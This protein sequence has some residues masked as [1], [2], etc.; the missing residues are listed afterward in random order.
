M[1]SRAD[2]QIATL[3]TADLRALGVH[4]YSD[5]DDLHFNQLDEPILR[6]TAPKVVRFQTEVAGPS[7]S[8]DV[9]AASGDGS[10][11]SRL[12][13]LKPINRGHA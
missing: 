6:Q 11:V 8:Q 4:K 7:A 3:M 5:I 2:W 13:G 12:R 9:R 1:S 10:L